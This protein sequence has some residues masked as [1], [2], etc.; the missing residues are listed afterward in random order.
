MSEP[1]SHSRRIWPIC[2]VGLLLAM[3]A[4]VWGVSAQTEQAPASTLPSELSVDNLKAQMKEDPSKLREAMRRDDLT[5][6]QRRELRDNM[7]QVWRSGMDERV[8]AYYA[9]ASQEDRDE[10]LDKQIDE[11]QDRSKEWEKRRAEWEKRRQ[12]REASGDQEG[13]EEQPERR[14]WRRERTQAERK[15]DSESRN[16]DQTARRMGYFTA[17]RQRMKQRGIEGGWGGHGGSGRR[18]GGHGGRGGPH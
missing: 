6:E 8:D 12:E 2:A 7:R 10:L 15:A 18:G 11:F 13:D 1:E 3:V 5:E 4:V 14:D 9:A 16:P 17:L